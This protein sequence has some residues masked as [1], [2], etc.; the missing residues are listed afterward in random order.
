MNTHISQLASR[1]SALLPLTLGLVALLAPGPAPAQPVGALDPTFAG[2]GQSLVGFAGGHQFGLAAAVQSERKLVI[3][4]ESADGP[5]SAVRSFEIVRFDTNN[6]LDLSFGAGGVVF[7]SFSIADG[8]DQVM[9]WS[10]NPTGKSLSPAP[11]RSPRTRT[12]P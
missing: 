7:T 10:S 12:L 4:G 11:A 3:A 1:K 9:R 6:V 8:F 5:G 2:S